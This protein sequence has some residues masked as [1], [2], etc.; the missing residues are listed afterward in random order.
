MRFRYAHATHPDGSTAVELCLA[1]LAQQ[2]ADESTQRGANLGF[3]YMTE[4]LRPQAQAILALLKM[5]TGIANWVGASAAAICATGVEYIDEPALAVMLGRFAPGSFNVFSGSQRP[6]ARGT[7]TD[8]SAAAAHTALV[9]ADPNEPGL[10]G[11]IED[12]AQKVES[13]HLFGG[14]A[15]GREPPVTIAD[16]VLQGGLSGVVFAADVPLVSRVTQGCHPLP[17]S[18]RR[19]ITASE[20]NLIGMLDEERAFDALLR[21]AGIVEN[22]AALNSDEQAREALTQLK[23]LGRR[24]LLFVGIEPEPAKSSRERRLR[25]DYLVRPVVAIDPSGGAVAVGTPVECGQTVRFCT[26]DEAAARKDLTR[27]CA[28]IRDHLHEQSE[29]RRR[30]LAAKGAVYVSCVGRGTYMFGEQSEELRLI[31]QQ[32]GDVPLVGFYANGEISGR[33]LYGFTGVLT[34]F[35]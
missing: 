33:S 17:G 13:G 10:A 6:P 21:D 1:Q 35:Y 29:K 31:A 32:L 9:H 3:I 15:S 34:V 14:L 30:P 4:A 2:A 19:K 23:L 12:M 20:D 25:D 26:R 28:E 7:R 8:R 27:I 22:V 5:R 24:G 11:L 16:R 18:R